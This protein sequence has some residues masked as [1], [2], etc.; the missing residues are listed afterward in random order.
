MVLLGGDLFHENKPS[1][2]AMYQ[3]LK[4]LRA[5]CLGDR[6]CALQVLSDQ[7]V[8]TGDT[9]VGARELAANAG[10]ALCHINYEDPDINV[11]IPVFS[12]NGNHDDPTGDGRISALDVLQ[13]AGLL[14]YYGRVPENDDIC[15]TPV[16]LQKGD[17]KLALYGMSNCR[18]ERLFRSFKQHQVRFMRPTLFQDEWFNLC[19][20]HQNQYGPSWKESAADGRQCRA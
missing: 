12:I 5:N 15:V 17:T 19:T 9:Y 11:S 6:P 2:M 18:D 7:S 16:L 3:V 14:N 10:S 13:I 1:R 4:S 20:V 8:T